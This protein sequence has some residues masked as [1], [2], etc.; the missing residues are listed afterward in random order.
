VR[1]AVV[2]V[3]EIF[4]SHPIGES[5]S[6]KSMGVPYSWLPVAGSLVCC[7]NVK[8][9]SCVLA[10]MLLYHDGLTRVAICLTGRPK[11]RGSLLR[12]ISVKGIGFI[13]ALPT[14][15]SL[16]NGDTFIR[17]KG[18][19]P[20]AQKWLWLHDHNRTPDRGFVPRLRVS[21]LKGDV[22]EQ[23]HTHATKDVIGSGFSEV[24]KRRDWD[25]F[26]ADLCPHPILLPVDRARSESKLLADRY[27]SSGF[28]AGFLLILSRV[29]L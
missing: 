8:N 4:R 14:S 1:K 10:V 16:D 19:H 27:N 11:E 26:D 2:A 13:D 12:I 6:H 15:D 20:E 9:L 28:L 24:Q 18:D 3:D 29:S 17:E 23:F 5:C 21:G 22:F 7:D 25:L